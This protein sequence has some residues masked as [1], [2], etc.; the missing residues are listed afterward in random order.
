MANDRLQDKYPNISEFE[1]LLT[2]AKYN[3]GTDKADAF[4]KDLKKK[5]DLYGGGMFWSDAQD[6]WLRKI[7]GDD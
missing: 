2:N 6:D 1:E 7:A 5:Y 3:A 4:V